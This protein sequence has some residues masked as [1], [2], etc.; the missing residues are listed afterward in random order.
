VVL[1]PQAIEGV[2]LT[3]GVMTHATKAKSCCTA[4]PKRTSWAD[5]VSSDDDCQDDPWDLPVADNSYSQAPVS[6]LENS[7][8]GLN[9]RLLLGTK[10]PA[11]EPKDFA[12]LFDGGVSKQEAPSEAGTESGGTSHIGNDF[13]A[14]EAR[15]DKE[16]PWNPS[17][18]ATEFLPTLSMACPIV[19]MC[20]I[21]PEEGELKPSFAAAGQ[22]DCDVAKT[23]CS[24]TVASSSCSG[25]SSPPSCSVDSP[26]SRLSTVDLGMPCHQQ[27]LKKRRRTRGAK[28]VDHQVETPSEVAT[29][30]D[31]EHRAEMRK[32]AVRIRKDTPEYVQYSEF[33]PKEVRTP[34]APMT[35]DP[36]DQTI[37]KRSWKSELSKWSAEL[38]QWFSD[39]GLEDNGSVL[40]ELKVEGTNIA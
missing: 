9:Q 19:G 3:L 11:A 21:I 38:N 4:I 35:P 10:L 16:C 5:I 27:A 15:T 30:E 23:V 14:S 22:L 6:G 25:C 2:V 37:S 39:H 20:Q 26:R 18:A 33:V 7:K 13:T 8:E 12:F 17:V 32:K 40:P 28:H 29:E 1:V 36:I 24:S 31:W 34:G